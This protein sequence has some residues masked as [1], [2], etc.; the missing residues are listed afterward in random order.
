MKKNTSRER[1]KLQRQNKYPQGNALSS[2]RNHASTYLRSGSNLQHGALKWKFERTDERI[3]WWEMEKSDDSDWRGILLLSL[4]SLAVI[5]VLMIAVFLI[6][7]ALVFVS[8]TLK[9]VPFSIPESLMDL[10][11]FG[12]LIA[13]VFA[14][15]LATLLI[16][17]RSN[18]RFEFDI[19]KKEIVF[20]ERCFPNR[21]VVTV[22]P[23]DSIIFI[24]PQTMTT[25]A[26]DGNIELSYVSKNGKAETN[27][28]GSQIPIQT[29]NEHVEW[30]IPVLGEKVQPLIEYD[31]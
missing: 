1:R 18:V 6:S 28:L 3:V 14:G 16:F 30:L 25:N 19:K 21:K 24:R 22:V 23:F 27:G 13:V 20:M 17:L 15:F 4:I 8:E 10:F 2:S 26:Y 7:G 31:T 11:W 5:F 12:F 9:G 29:L